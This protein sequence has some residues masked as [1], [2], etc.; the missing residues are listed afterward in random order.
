VSDTTGNIY[1]LRYDLTHI[2]IS[3]PP[4]NKSPEIIAMPGSILGTGGPAA[5]DREGT[6]FFSLI[7]WQFHWHLLGRECMPGGNG[8]PLTFTDPIYAIRTAGYS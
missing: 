4:Y 3:A 1:D 7:Q 5:F 8:H 2:E 6:L